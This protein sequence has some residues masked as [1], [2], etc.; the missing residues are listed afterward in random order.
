MPTPIT[1]GACRI[2]GHSSLIQPTRSILQSSGVTPTQATECAPRASP[3]NRPADRGEKQIDPAKRV[4]QRPGLGGEAGEGR[5]FQRFAAARAGGTHPV[6]SP[7]ACS[8]EHPVVRPAR[9]ALH[10]GAVAHQREVPAFAAR[11]AFV[12]LGLGFGAAFGLEA[13]GL[14]RARWRLAASAGL[15]ASRSATASCSASGLQRG[16]AFDWSAPRAVAP[17]RAERGDVAAGRARRR[18]WR[19]RASPTSLSVR[20]RV[21]PFDS[22]SSRAAPALAFLHALAERVEAG[23]ASDRHGRGRSAP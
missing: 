9:I 15:P 3:L 23:L 21:R 11:L 12:A 18:R 4:Q 13:R 1:R 16:G 14:A 2:T 7:T 22:I 8:Y 19:R 5:L 20:E 10:A 6:A 17:A